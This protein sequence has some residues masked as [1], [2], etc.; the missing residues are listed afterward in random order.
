MT[1]TR[2]Y[3]YY[4]LIVAAFVTVLLCSALIGA[5]KVA[6]LQLPFFDTVVCSAGVL[7]FPISYFFGD[8]LTEV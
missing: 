7:F 8:I 5:G 6:Q 2:R 1:A 3:R 4:D